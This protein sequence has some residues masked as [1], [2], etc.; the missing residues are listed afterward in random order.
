VTFVLFDPK[1]PESR[2]SYVDI[3][4][5]GEKTGPSARGANVAHAATPAATVAARI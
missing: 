2:I 4:P 3:V 1:L 5:A